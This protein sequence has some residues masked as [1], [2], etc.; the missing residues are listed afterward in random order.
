MAWTLTVRTGGTVERERFAS[1][2]EVLDAA[3][4]RARTL[5]ESAP[6]RPLDLRYK[7]LEPVQQVFARV[8]LAGP[9]RLLA[10][11]RAGVDIRGDGSAEPYLGRM[12]RRAIDLTGGESATAALK[13][14]LLGCR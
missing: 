13:R 7:R 3:E 10:S 8:E 9:E 1:L 6:K 2:E 12:R 14:V 4:A 5:A 11:V